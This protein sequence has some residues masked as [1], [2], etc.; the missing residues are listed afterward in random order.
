MLGAYP[1]RSLLG[2]LIPNSKGSEASGTSAR[3]MITR[4]RPNGS[5]KRKRNRPQKRLTRERQL[6]RLLKV[7]RLRSASTF[8]R[9]LRSP[10]QRRRIYWRHSNYPRVFTSDACILIP[11][12]PGV[13]GPYTRVWRKRTG[14]GRDCQKLPKV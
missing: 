13:L 2:S 7:C 10:C 3:S 14:Q 12:R 8:G 4:N 9:S 6:S 5:R 1:R 11:A